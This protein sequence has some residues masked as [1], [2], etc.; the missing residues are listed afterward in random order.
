M[1]ILHQPEFEVSL[2]PEQ[3]R[4]FFMCLPWKS[5]RKDDHETTKQWR[6]RCSFAVNILDEE[7]VLCVSFQIFIQTRREVQE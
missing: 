3:T 1:E 7:F 6:N 4:L 5:W 2:R